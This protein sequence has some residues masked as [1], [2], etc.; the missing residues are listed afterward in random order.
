MRTIPKRLPTAIA[1]STFLALPVLATPFADTLATIAKTPESERQ[2]AMDKVAAEGTPVASGTEVTFLARK[3]DEN[4]PRVVGD[5]NAWGRYPDEQGPLGGRMRNVEGSDWYF[6]TMVFPANA[7]LE[8]GFRYGTS[9]TSPDPGNPHG[10]TTFGRPVSVLEMPDWRPAPWFN[11]AETATLHG[12]LVKMT[13]QDDKV[14]GG[15]TIHVFLPPDYPLHAPYPVVYF[16]DGGMYVD[17]VAMPVILDR[18]IGRH[19]VRPLIGVFVDPID[20][21]SEYVGAP[22]FLTWFTNELVPTIDQKYRTDPKPESRAL[23]GSSRGALAALILSFHGEPTFGHVGLLEPAIAPSHILEEVEASPVRPIDFQVVAGIFDLRF[24]GDAYQIVDR[25]RWKGY[26]VRAGYESIG[27][28]PHSWKHYI[29]RMIM[30]F[31]PGRAVLRRDAAR[32]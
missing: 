23:I 22:E 31:F 29:P 2:A 13:M 30:G 4:E 10:N 28:T 6:A 27:H 17:D 20:R 26:A 16:N 18:L 15:R 32:N 9:A 3:K 19:A 8:Y 7:R 25:L 1:L 21:R 24:I 5:F 11:E 12:K 14:E